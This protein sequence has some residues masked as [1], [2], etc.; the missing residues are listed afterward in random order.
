[1]KLFLGS[2]AFASVLTFFGI[3]TSDNNGPK[4]AEKNFTNY[5]SSCHGERVVAF[6]DR[7]W[8]HGNSKEEIIKSISNGY[9]DA[10]MPA[11]KEVLKPQE[12]EDLADLIVSKLGSVE[13]YQFEDKVTSNHFSTEKIKVALDTIATGLDSPW[14][15]A[16]LP[17]NSFLITD[18]AGKLY[19]V[20][21]NQNKTEIK[22]IPD[23]LSRGQ[24]GVL[25]LVLH[26]NFKDNGWI[27]M[28]YSK[29][30]KIDGVENT[31]TAIVRG[32]IKNNQFVD[33]E[34]LFVSS[35][36]TKTYHHFGSRITFDKAGKM[37]FSVGER[38]MEK[39]FPQ[40]TDNDN[41][42]IHRL[43]D[44][45][46]IPSDNPFVGKDPEKFHQS[47]YSYGQRNPQGLT[48]NPFNGEIW[49]TEHGPR[50]GDE[51]NIIQPGR[52]Y[53]WPVISYGINY[54]GKPITDISS[55]E[56]MEQPQHYWIPSIAPSGLTFVSSDKYPAWK[57]N[58]MVGS[59]RFKY[60]NR[61]EIQN[62]K[63]IHEEK[64]FPNLGRMRNVIQGQDGYLYIAVEQPGMVFR[65]RQEMD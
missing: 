30:K 44:D 26:P 15:M 16:Q 57:G 60:L 18:R 50:G 21:Q 62:G 63:V 23:A 6:V 1:M 48:T 31:A 27:Y 8:V 64:L 20:D 39:V 34:E 2:I 4:D 25:D 24:G 3:N 32:H 12:I 19:H 43:N 41:G 52:N 11:W 13:Q 61:C 37:Y 65:V 55:K 10:G 22:G 59:L 5:C 9:S 51:L 42:K 17:D 53:G 36:F 14:G 38:G 29:H 28:S 46:S 33:Q 49:E 47:I 58:L 35:P 40:G 54:N 7:K 45:G 56:G